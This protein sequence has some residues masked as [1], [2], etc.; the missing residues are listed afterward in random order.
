M[1]VD[2]LQDALAA[3]H[4]AVWLYGVLGART[5]A[6]ARPALF[7]LLTAAYTTHRGRRDTLEGFLREAGAEPVAAADAYEL[8]RLDS[9]ALVTAEARRVEAACATTYA[10]T[11]AG[12]TGVVRAW[13]AA[14]LV[15]TAV[16][17]LDLGADPEALPGS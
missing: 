6:S 13:A 11:V 2:V 17:E 4:A 1:S 10:T 3:E 15:D 12:T 16:R 5:S 14:A 8:P 7:G 9:P